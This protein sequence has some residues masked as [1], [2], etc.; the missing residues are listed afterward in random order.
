[1]RVEEKELRLQST[2]WTAEK[3]QRESD[4]AT[5][6]SIDQQGKGLVEPSRLKIAGVGNASIIGHP[7]RHLNS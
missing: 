6:H 2:Q 5:R 7:K 1:M 3:E 4:V